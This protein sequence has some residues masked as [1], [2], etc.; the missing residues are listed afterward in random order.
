M[1]GATAAKEAPTRAFLSRFDMVGVDADVA[2]A[3]VALRRSHRMKLPD[4]II[5]ATARR[6]GWLLV[7][8]SQKVASVGGF[9]GGA[10]LLGWRLVV[11]EA[12][13]HDRLDGGE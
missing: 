13:R 11:N 5:W 3:A 4:A 6:R 7:L 9:A 8:L 1:V 10:D 2:E 12:R